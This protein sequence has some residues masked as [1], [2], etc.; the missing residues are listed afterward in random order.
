MSEI[1]E[2][3]ERQYC[4]LSDSLSRDGTSLAFLDGGTFIIKFVNSKSLFS[5][6]KIE[7]SD[8]IIVE[9]LFVFCYFGSWEVSECWVLFMNFRTKEAENLQN[10]V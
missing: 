7:I 5:S 10:K 9:V 3:Y 8:R 1:Y 6:F 2:G 4:E